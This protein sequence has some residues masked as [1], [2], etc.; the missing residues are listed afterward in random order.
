MCRAPIVV[1][2]SLQSNIGPGGPQPAYFFY[3]SGL[4]GSVDFGGWLVRITGSDNVN[5]STQGM[6]VGNDIFSD[7]ELLRFELDYQ[8]GS[9]VYAMSTSVDGFDVGEQLYYLA[10]DMN[11]AST[12]GIVTVDD[13]TAG[14]LSFTAPDGTSLYAVDIVAGPATAVRLTSLTTVQ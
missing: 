11:G 4:F 5:P 13:L 9:A 8:P 10:T 14:Q 2:T 12:N 3:G 1:T 6:G 7:G